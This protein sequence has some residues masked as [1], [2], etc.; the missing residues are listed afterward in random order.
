MGGGDYQEMLLYMY[1]C[2]LTV[3]MLLNRAGMLCDTLSCSLLFLPLASDGIAVGPIIGPTLAGGIIF[4]VML[5]IFVFVGVHCRRRYYTTAVVVTQ[6]VVPRVAT[7][8]ISSQSTTTGHCVSA[9][10]STYQPMVTLPP[11]QPT[12]IIL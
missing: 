8:F 1:I 10:T 6:P 2:T 4:T 7:T 11:P 3:C 9:S 12:H 5:I